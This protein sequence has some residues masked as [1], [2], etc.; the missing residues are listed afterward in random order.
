RLRADFPDRFVEE[1]GAVWDGERRALV[2]R[3]ESRFDRIVLDSRPAGRVDP[4]QAAQ[5]L[6]AAV[7]ELGLEALPWT[8]GLRQWQARAVSLRQWMPELGLPDRGDAALLA[9]LDEWL[10]P[11]F[12]GK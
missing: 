1:E 6:T 8:E 3:R 9:T 12:A 4:A 11:A 5:A 2:A 10:K 7:R